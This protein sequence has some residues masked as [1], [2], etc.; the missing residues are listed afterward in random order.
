MQTQL[1]F[2]KDIDDQLDADAII[3]DE[4]SMVDISLMHHFLNAVPDGCRL[5]LVGDTDQ[6]PAVGPG[7]VLK[8]II[9]S[10]VIPSI[11]LNEIFRQAQTSMIIQNAHIINAGRL[12]IS[13]V[14]TTISF[15]TKS[16]T[17]LSSRKKFSN[18]A[19]PFCRKKAMTF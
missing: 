12:P 2:A 8:D 4:V 7:S 18:C 15:F 17:T 19:P 5:I 14:N 3:L 16:T 11:R 6:L 10:G 1:G 9:R 13:A